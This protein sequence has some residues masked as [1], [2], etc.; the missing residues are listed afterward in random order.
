[1]RPNR[2]AAVCAVLA[3]APAVPWLA[4]PAPEA[5]S[6]RA[7]VGQEAPA[8]FKEELALRVGRWLA[9]NSRYRSEQEPFDEYGTEWTW[10]VGRHSVEGRLFGLAGGVEKGTFWEFRC[11]WDPG[12][13]VAILEQWG[14]GGAYGQGELRSIGP[15][16]TD[17]VQVFR[18]PGQPEL[19]TR[20][21]TTLTADE[22]RGESQRL[23]DGAWKPNRSYVWKRVR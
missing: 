2:I 15:G 9:D 19:A 7:T 4:Q 11:F 1:M 22:E 13:R 20:H 16:R 18:A 10:G 8:W 5:P 3:S 14:A 21:L 17:L 6:L 23:V 12:A